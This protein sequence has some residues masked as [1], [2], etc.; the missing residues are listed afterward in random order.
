MVVLPSCPFPSIYWFNQLTNKEEVWIDSSENYPKQTYR[1]RYDI[2]GPNGRQS[3]TLPVHR[4]SG[5]KTP[6]GEIQISYGSWVNTHLGA[7]RSAYGK[8][9]FF[10]HFIDE[11][12]SLYTRRPAL[13]IDFNL[14]SLQII[15]RV[16]APQIKVAYTSEWLDFKE[17]DVRLHFEPSFVAP[18]FKAYPQVFSDRFPFQNNLSVLDLVFNMGPKSKE[19]IDY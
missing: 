11:I 5:V 2:L 3:L 6:I 15:Q 9:A 1:N 16:I 12:A 4:P 8:A 13:L 14:Q 7:I 10:D 19:Y 17:N 18:N